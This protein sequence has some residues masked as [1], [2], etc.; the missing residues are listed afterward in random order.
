MAR[1]RHA[2]NPAL[3]GGHAEIERIMLGYAQAVGERHAEAIY[4]R[5]VAAIESGLPYRC[6]MAD[7]PPGSGLPGD[8][9]VLVGPDGS[10]EV[11][12]E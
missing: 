4:A 8:V 2:A 3:R 11:V 1:R 9:M 7:L 5:H 10:V 6:R 12:A